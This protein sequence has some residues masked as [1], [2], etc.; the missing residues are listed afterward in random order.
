MRDSFGAPGLAVTSL[1]HDVDENV[2]RMVRVID[3][4]HRVLTRVKYFVNVKTGDKK[5]I[6]DTWDRNKIAAQVAASGGLIQV[7]D[8]KGYKIRW[9]V[10]A[11]DFVLHDK[12]SP[13]NHFT[14]VPYFPY[15]RY[16]RTIGLVE[17]LIDPQELLN[18]TTSQEL[19]I[20]NSMANSGWKIK[21]NS[22]KNMTMDELEQ[23][24]SKTGVVIE[25]DDVDNAE[26]IQPNQIPQGLDRLSQKGE[27][28]IKSVS[29]RGDAQ[30]GMTRADVSAAQIEANN[31][32]SDVGLRKPMDNLKRTDHIM[33]RNILD[34]VQEFYTD[35]RIM[36]ITHNALT[37]ETKDIVVNWPDPETGEIQNDLSMGEYDITI[38]SQPARQTLEDSQFEQAAYLREKL[39]VQIPDEF[40][41]ENSRLVNKT[42]LVQAI[43]AQKESPQAQ[44]QEQ[45]KILG[46]K[47][48]VAELKAQVAKDEAD[49]LHRRAKSA[50]EI[51]ETNEIVSGKPEEQAQA[52]QEM[53]IEAQK[54]EQEMAMMREKHK[55][56]MEIQAEKARADIEAKKMLAAEEARLKRAQAIMAERQKATA[57]PAGK[58]AA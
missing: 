48:Q 5:L 58:K 46:Q 11:D 3:R 19:H 43:K 54:H 23:F 45:I 6:P 13:Y 12:W 7:L 20:V 52:K 17:N 51:A 25:L 4:Q 16:G 2:E 34:M 1:H 28:Y 18:K 53:E 38:I 15:F 36:T 31:A 37:G 56:E 9:T 32:F 47:L 57:Q 44:E 26:K 10:T 21:T 49:A 41:V 39:G 42:A 33:A 35:H 30:M 8:A 22:L 27:N 14:I 55:L 29:M 50:K 40:L 24:G